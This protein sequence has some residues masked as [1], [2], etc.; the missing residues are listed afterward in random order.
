MG[1]H[2]RYWLLQ[3][4]G[5]LVLALV[6]YWI[7]QRGWIELSHALLLLLAWFLKDAILFPFV[8]ESYDSRPRPVRESLVGK[9]GEV[10]RRGRNHL[11]VRVDGELWRAESD[12]E[13]PEERGSPVLVRHAEGMTL[14]VTPAEEGGANSAPSSPLHPGWDPGE[15]APHDQQRKG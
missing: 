2:V 3:L 15:S 4:P 11:F 5:T 1:V 12:D 6:L 13:I 14:R 9:R 7:R 8:R 10:V